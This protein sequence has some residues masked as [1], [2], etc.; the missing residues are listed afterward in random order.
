MNKEVKSA[1]RVLDLL[2]LLSGQQEPIRFSALASALD[3]PKSSLHGLLSTLVARGYALK[4]DTDR[5]RIADSFLGGFGW[6]GGFET[7]L[8]SVAQPVVESIWNRL[9]ET[10]LVCV[11]TDRQEARQICKA[12]SRQTI[13]YDS[14]EKTLLPGYG[15]V[16]GRVLLAFQPEKVIDDYLATTE[17]VPFTP[18]TPLNVEDI[19][20]ALAKIRA[21]GFGEIVDEYA[22]GGAGVAA[23]IRNAAGRVVAVIDVAT[24]T[25]RYTARRD[26]MLEAVLDGARRISERLGYREAA[27]DIAEET[28]KEGDA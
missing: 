8:R 5:Y 18:L 2:E 28:S 12:V 11:R 1:A 3:I 9:D 25:P 7:L 19:R 26:E 10:V 17:L 27:Q 21:N 4:D 16:M 22:M 13:R 20:K 15:S 14:S 23:P 6:V 24:V